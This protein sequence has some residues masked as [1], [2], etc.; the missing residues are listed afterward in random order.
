MYT[1]NYDDNTLNSIKITI[2][3]PQ[4]NI[5]INTYDCM[6]F[7]S[8]Q[9]YIYEQNKNFPINSFIP[10]SENDNLILG[11]PTDTLEMLNIKNDDMIKI[12]HIPIPI[13]YKYNNKYNLITMYSLNDTILDVKNKIS[14]KLNTMPAKIDLRLNDVY[15]ANENTLLDYIDSIY[16]NYDQWKNV[17]I[18]IRD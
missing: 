4:K 5:T 18:T 14:D 16:Y 8:L 2:V 13:Y 12:H 17:T 7:F 3:T 1:E 6:T 15:C 10:Y 11:E 9:Y